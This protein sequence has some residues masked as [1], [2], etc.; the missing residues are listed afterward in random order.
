MSK[1]DY[2][3]DENNDR[4]IVNGDFAIGD[5]S[6]A[7]ALTILNASKGSLRQF[8]DI[9]IELV[10]Y[11]KSS[12]SDDILYNSIYDGLSNEGFTVSDIEFERD[13]KSLTISITIDNQVLKI[14][15]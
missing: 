9:G 11:V 13:G 6:S 7:H 1:L 2:M 14:T 4:L 12:A 10:N 3:V 5:N 15:I 8:P